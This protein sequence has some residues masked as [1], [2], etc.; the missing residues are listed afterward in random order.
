MKYFTVIIHWTKL[1]WEEGKSGWGWTLQKYQNMQN[2][3]LNRDA[4]LS[5]KAMGGRVRKIILICTKESLSS[6]L[7]STLKQVA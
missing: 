1:R 7:G 5:S 6:V 3:V 4:Q 2:I